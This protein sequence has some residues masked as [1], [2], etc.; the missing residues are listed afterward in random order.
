MGEDE[1]GLYVVTHENA[2]VRSSLAMESPVVASLHARQVVRVVEVA[3]ADSEGRLRG[4][5]KEPAGWISL[6]DLRT[7]YRWAR[8]QHASEPPAPGADL[9]HELEGPP[10]NR[11]APNADPVHKWESPPPNKGKSRLVHEINQ[12]DAL[13]RQL[14]TRAEMLRSESFARNLEYEARAQ[15]LEAKLLSAHIV[16]IR[17][18]PRRQAR[19][20]PEPHDHEHGSPAFHTERSDHLRRQIV[21]DLTLPP[22][23]RVV[24]YCLAAEQPAKAMATPRPA[25]DE[26]PAEPGPEA[27]PWALPVERIVRSNALVLPSPLHPGDPRRELGYLR[28]VH[29]VTWPPLIV[30]QQN[31]LGRSDLLQNPHFKAAVAGAL[32]DAGSSVHWAAPYA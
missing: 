25:P 16:P 15:A 32:G 4:R 11:M 28:N 21:P 29:P 6:L 9:L 5:I 13:I 18:E 31:Y 17:H 20:H 14:L 22:G 30:A 24:G 2:R 26:E 23:G 10:H 12:R 27:L 19:H 1:P 3:R 7:G 8:R